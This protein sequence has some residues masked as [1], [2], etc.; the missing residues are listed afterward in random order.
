MPKT[1]KDSPVDPSIKSVYE[2]NPFDPMASIRMTGR[3]LGAVVKSDRKMNPLILIGSLI[4][5]AAFLLLGIFQNSPL[6]A[7]LGGVILLNI[8]SNI[9]KFRRS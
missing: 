6:N 9:R 3:F 5:G 4:L 7:I 8:V 2:S 1:S